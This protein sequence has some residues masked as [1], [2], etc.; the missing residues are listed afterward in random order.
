MDARRGGDIPQGD[1]HGAHHRRWSGGA[2]TDGRLTTIR[3]MAAD[4]PAPRRRTPGVALGAR[5]RAARQTAGVSL[6]ELA[7]RLEV[8]PSLLSQIERG[9][10]QPSVGTLWAIVTELGLSLDALFAPAADDGDRPALVQRA[11]RREALELGGGVRWERLTAAPDPHADFAF[12]TYAPGGDAPAD[13]PPASHAGRE[14]GYLVSG[15][16]QIE[17][18]DEVLELG[19]GDSIVFGSETPHRFRALGDTPARAVWL[20]LARV[21]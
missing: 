5:V 21:V 14:Y 8:S 12:V 17:V 6:R 11:D 9:L 19:P 16:L 3:A 4:L 7:R 1:G 18:G 10:A 20:N 15:R 2:A 13:A